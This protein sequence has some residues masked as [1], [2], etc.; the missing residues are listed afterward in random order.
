MTGDGTKKERP[1]R[2]EGGG[3]GQRGLVGKRGGLG[4]GERDPVLGWQAR[5][6][7]G[8]IPLV[9]FLYG[10]DEGRLL[11]FLDLIRTK[12]L[13]E[14]SRPFNLSVFDARETPIGKILET[15]RT[16][17]VLSAWRVVVANNA[18]A[19]GRSEWGE[20]ISYARR[21]SHSACLVLRGERQPELPEALEAIRKA[22]AVLEFKA[23]TEPQARDWIVNRV[24][25]EG[26]RIL[27][28][29]INALIGE[30]GTMQ[31]ALEG[32][33]EKLLL[34][35]RDKT[36]I[37]EE[38]VQEV[39]AGAKRHRVFDLADALGERREADAL[40]ILHR[41]LEERDSHLKVLGMLAR[42]V[43]LIWY[44][45]D[46]VAS[47]REVSAGQ[48]Q[49]PPFARARLLRQAQGWDEPSLRRALEGLVDLDRAFKGGRLG[50]EVL[51][52]RWILRV[53][54]G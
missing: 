28:E 17:P 38:E 30:V 8:E 4:F 33:V 23:R 48:G 39:T 1:G 26:K 43:R 6:E 51:L 41:L 47:G 15:A 27:P 36:T 31:G 32:E 11:S 5:L 49:V 54:R 44:T 50:P 9:L 13:K 45:K 35:A 19:L 20:V 34:Y 7:R 42:Q 18:S 16:V 10:E 52:D 21:P 24:R 14:G 3:G 53:C 37:G 12:C 22:G 40:R 2:K 46:S 25:R 29:A